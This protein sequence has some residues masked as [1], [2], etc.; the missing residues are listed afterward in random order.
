MNTIIK[1][2]LA[3]LLSTTLALS[4]QEGD[5]P[6][7]QIMLTRKADLTTKLSSALGYEPARLRVLDRRSV[8]F[9]HLG[10][11][12]DALKVEDP[13]TGEGRRVA[14]TADGEVADY[15]E[16][17]RKD[18]VLRFEKYG[19][20]QLALYE[21]VKQPDRKEIPVM[22]QIRL[23]E[24]E[25]DKS[26]LP[27]GREIEA[28]SEQVSKIRTEQEKQVR[29]EYETLMKEIGEGTKR[30]VKISGP[31]VRTRLSTEAV[32]KL[33]RN[34]QVA[35]IGLDKEL[36]V[37]DYPTIAESLPTTKTNSVHSTGN[38]GSGVKIAILE[39]GSLTKPD[40]CFNIAEL[41]DAGAAGN[42]HMTKSAAIIGN[43]YNTSTGACDGSWTGYA[44]DASVYIAND[45]DYQDGYD[46]A[47]SKTANVITMSWHYPSEETSGGFHSRD[48]YFDYYSTH[49]PWPSIFTSAGNQAGID[50][51]AS[52]KG[53]N[54][55]GVGNVLN[56]DDGDRCNDVISSSSSWENPTS[57]HSDREIPEIASPGS[58]HELLDTSFGGTSAATPV[59][60]A[61]SAVLMSAN[62]SLKVWPEAIRAILLATANYQDSDGA[63]WSTG[64]DG[65][66][67][68]GMTNTLYG[69]YTAQRRET[70][71]SAQYRAH[72][73]GSI[74]HAD[75]AAGYFNKTWKAYT[76]TTLSRIRVALTWNSK[77]TTAAGS[78]TSSVLDADLDLRVYDPDGVWVA[79]SA[80]W[81]SNYEFVEF[82]PSKIG[83]YTIKIRGWTVP[84]DFS[85][86]YGIAWTTHY[87]LCS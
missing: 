72:D 56:E 62:T 85:S 20:L 14:I 28:A 76:G 10:E 2:T 19:N 26:K 75:F 67:G 50:A 22:L 27:P 21:L 8:T 73:Y 70:G 53:Y 64:S 17:R 60:A 23:K 54:F 33:S 57:P 3:V 30:E 9:R 79:T 4:S 32:Q 35:F 37:Q 46:W 13:K 48:I 11:K 71:S 6:S 15:D 39:S 87:D 47:K 83:E 44:P 82:T 51:Y 31:F 34:P 59:T 58:R 55:F 18:L 66:D 77:T 45:S 65:K 5:F 61:I 16:L 24:P 84:A 25:I 69:Y 38:T 80:S 36:I 40:A 41:Q 49:F 78:P 81:D 29:Q 63:T 74:R 12:V 42:S 1:V 7:E 86:Y 52:G 43:R 68:T